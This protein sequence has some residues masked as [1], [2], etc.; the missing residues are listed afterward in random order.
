M[1]ELLEEPRPWLSLSHPPRGSEVVTGDDWAEYFPTATDDWVSTLA[2]SPPD[3][4]TFAGFA[5]VDFT[6]LSLAGQAEALRLMRECQSFWEARMAELRAVMAGPEPATA[7]DALDDFTAAEVAVAEGC[8]LYAAD[9]RIRLAR[10]LAGRLA[11]SAARVRAGTMTMEQARALSEAAAPLSD[12]IA[13]ELETRMLRLV[14]RQSLANFRK[15]LRRNLSKVDPDWER[16]AKRARREVVVQHTPGEEGTG[17]LYLRGPLETTEQIDRVLTAEAGRTKA[18]LGGTSDQRK[19]VALRDMSERYLASPDAARNH[20]RLPEVQVAVGWKELLGMQDGV[21]E[22]PGVGTIPLEAAR[23]LLADGAPMRRL[24]IDAEV[25]GKLLD[26]GT[27]TYQA[28]AA[29]AD[30]LIALNVTSAAP[31]STVPA[32]VSDMEHNIP[33]DQGGP[34][35][36]LNVTPVDR[37]WHRAKTHGSWTYRKD[38]ETRKVVWNAPSGQTFVIDPYDYRS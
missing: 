11:R 29:L 22:I 16:R 27:T 37:R 8:S 35:D 6:L 21:A 2:C 34:T 7:P 15:S 19:L 17:E 3:E 14:S 36:P 24:L 12:D 26:Y 18:E 23:W 30:Y 33:H 13:H 4:G 32:R 38:P 5:E 9:G 31:H 28:P 1:F 10:D 25:D 20:G